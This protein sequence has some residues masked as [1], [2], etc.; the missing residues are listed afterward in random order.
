MKTALLTAP[1]LPLAPWLPLLLHATTLAT[2]ALIAR[3][4]WM[5]W[6]QLEPGCAPVSR[7]SGWGVAVLCTAVLFWWLPSVGG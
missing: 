2:F 1:G 3:Y 6:R 4:G 5:L 7:W